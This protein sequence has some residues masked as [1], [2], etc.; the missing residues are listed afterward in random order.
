MIEGVLGQ[1]TQQLTQGFGTMQGVA[2]GQPLNLP[3]ALVAFRHPEA[4]R[5]SRLTEV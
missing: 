4:T 5:Y 3:E 1:V 2:V